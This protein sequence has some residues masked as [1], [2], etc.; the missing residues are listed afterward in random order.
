MS[1]R[2]IR[3]TPKDF[4]FQQW[5]PLSTCGL[6]FLIL[7]LC[8]PSFSN[9]VAHGFSCACD[10]V[11]KLGVPL[12][13]P[14]KKAA[15]VTKKELIKMMFLFFFGK[16]LSSYTSPSQD[17]SQHATYRRLSGRGSLEA[18]DLGGEGGEVMMMTMTREGM[19]TSM[20]SDPIIP[21]NTTINFSDEENGGSQL[22]WTRI[23]NGWIVA[24]LTMRR[25][26]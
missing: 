1:R 14:H 13:P 18:A 19:T 15:P 16:T 6:Y 9:V 10:C 12:A 4:L 24:Q 21:A 7:T 11:A 5:R 3:A 17:L 20:T 22:L 26:G 8:H 2:T 25:S 23:F